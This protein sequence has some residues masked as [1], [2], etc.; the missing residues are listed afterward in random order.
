MQRSGRMLLFT[1]REPESLVDLASLCMSHQRNAIQLHLRKDVLLPVV[2]QALIY[3]LEYFIPS[4]SDGCL[5]FTDLGVFLLMICM[6]VL[7]ISILL[8]RQ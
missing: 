8:R 3:H 7:A 2:R 5:L 4:V 1:R 6:K